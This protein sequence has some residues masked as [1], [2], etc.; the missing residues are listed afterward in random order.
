MSGLVK[1]RH[2]VAVSPML[3]CLDNPKKLRDI[4]MKKTIFKLPT[5]NTRFSSNCLVFSFQ[6]TELH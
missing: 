3:A 2:G 5:V 6:H 1:A 4:C